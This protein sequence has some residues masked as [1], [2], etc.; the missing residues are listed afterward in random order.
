RRPPAGRA[1]SPAETPR[2]TRSSQGMA[3]PRGA[4]PRPHGAT[5]VGSTTQ[6]CHVLGRRAILP[7]NHVELDTLAFG[8]RLEAAALNGGV[9]DEAVL[10]AVL[11]R[12]EAESLRVVEPLD[13]PGDT[14]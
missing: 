6:L 5:D 14:H 4:S 2:A 7:L 12:D 11:T 8:Q 1:S 13:G 3:R 10:L 9:M